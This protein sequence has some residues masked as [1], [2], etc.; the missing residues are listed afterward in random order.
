MIFRDVLA[1]RRAAFATLAI[2]WFPPVLVVM[3][4]IW[5]DSQMA[6]YL[7]LGIALLL[8]R[9]RVLALAVLV[10]VGALRHN[11]P[12]ATLAPLV[13]LLDRRWWIG[14]AA[15]LAVTAGSFAVD[16]LLVNQ[17]GPSLTDLIEVTDIQ[18]TAT[19]ADPIPD[20]DLRELLAGTNL[21]VDHDIQRALAANYAPK[22]Y[23]EFAEHPQPLE[24]STTE[25]Q[26]AAVQH[27][28]LTL[29]LREPLAYLHH[30]WDMFR[31]VLE[32]HA[33]S[34]SSVFVVAGQP[35]LIQRVAFWFVRAIGRVWYVPFVYFVVGLF[36]LGFARTR[37]ELALLG[38]GLVYELAL[39]PVAL[40][41]DYR[42]SHWMILS[43]TIAVV[44]VVI[45]RTGCAESRPT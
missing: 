8:R 44:L 21:T 36:T 25:A 10:V 17:P 29:A 5:K 27:A 1:P 40:T 2:T 4:V 42:Y 43:T 41:A 7:V 13:L 20:D 34:T 33:S 37:L 23:L 22:L 28:W 38:S 26:H 19:F 30:H 18:G 9:R 39:F 31:R 45:R 14:L 12:A 6:G 32:I 3:G 24:L 11:A 35:S 15:W 16:G